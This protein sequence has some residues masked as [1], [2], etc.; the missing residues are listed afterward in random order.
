MPYAEYGP[1]Y[2][3]S[4]FKDDFTCPACSTPLT[5]DTYEYEL[6]KAHCR[7]AIGPIRVSCPAKLCRMRFSLL[8]NPMNG[9]TTAFL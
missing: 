5:L 6:W 3:L 1:G 4:G 9:Q 8:M 7:G 2:H